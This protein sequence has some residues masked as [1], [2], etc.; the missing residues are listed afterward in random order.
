MSE[1]ILGIDRRSPFR[2][3]QLV[4]RPLV[5]GTGF[6]VY[7]DE[8][9]L[10]MERCHVF[11]EMLGDERGDLLNAVIGSEE[12]AQADSSVE[13]L[14][15]LVDV[16]D[17]L[18]LG[19]GEKFL[20]EPLCRYRHFA[21]GHGVADRQRC[22]VLNR[23][24]D[25]VLVEIV[26]LVIDSEYL[27]GAFSVR[28]LVNWR[29]GESDDCRVGHGCHQIGA[30]FLGDRAVRLVDKYVHVVAGIGVFLHPLKLVDHG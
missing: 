21:W 2:G 14:V 24:G 22:F 12:G 4:E 23:L 15:E 29:A 6:A 20:V 18:H 11:L 30:Q 17:A 1:V 16:G 3:Q 28:S 19:E 13:D 5:F 9:R 26:Q 27:E 8:K 7:A 10:V 25:G